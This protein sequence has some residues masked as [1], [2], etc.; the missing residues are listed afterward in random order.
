MKDDTTGNL[1]CDAKVTFFT[2]DAGQVLTPSTAASD[3]EVPVSSPVCQWDIVSGGGTY[4]VVATAPGFAQG[5]AKVELSSD[6]C[7]SATA[8]VTVILVRSGS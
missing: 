3:A 4:V 6:E 2:G 5:S 7:G 8:P 1:L